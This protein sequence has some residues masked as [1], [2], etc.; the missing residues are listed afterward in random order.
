MI[1]RSVPGSVLV[2]NYAPSYLQLNAAGEQL[3]GIEQSF[4]IMW[5]HATLKSTYICIA[6]YVRTVYKHANITIHGKNRLQENLSS[7]YNAI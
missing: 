2:L 7:D 6:M 1:Y 4:G 3:R 5:K